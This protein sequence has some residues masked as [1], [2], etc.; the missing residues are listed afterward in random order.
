MKL[1]SSVWSEIQLSCLHRHFRIWVKVYRSIVLEKMAAHG[2]DRY[3]LC[4]VK[5]WLEGWVQKVV[6]N[7]LKCSW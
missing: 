6:V 7:G 4:W 1:T 3:I 2:L 5:N